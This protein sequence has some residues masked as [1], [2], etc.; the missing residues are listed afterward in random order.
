MITSGTFVDS[1]RAMQSAIYRNNVDHGFWDETSPDELAENPEYFGNKLMLVVSELVEAH[2]DLR[3][4]DPERLGYFLNEQGKPEGFSTEIADAIIRL[5]DLSTHL[6]LD[7]GSVIM[8][9]HEYNKTR[10]YK[11][12]KAF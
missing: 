1:I 7:I 6:G 4:G 12:G 3:S 9:K 8:A 2:D 5:L 10:P 11:H